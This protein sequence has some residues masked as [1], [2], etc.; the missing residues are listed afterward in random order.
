MYKDTVLVINKH[1]FPGHLK[2]LDKILQKLEEAELHVTVGKSFFG[3]T[4]TD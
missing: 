4:V 2:A 1:V 3:C